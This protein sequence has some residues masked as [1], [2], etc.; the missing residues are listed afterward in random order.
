MV[1]V[2]NSRGRSRLVELVEQGSVG[3][4][5]FVDAAGLLLDDDVSGITVERAN[6]NMRAD[7]AFGHNGNARIRNTGRHIVKIPPRH[8]STLVPFNELRND[9]AVIQ[10]IVAAH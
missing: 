9:L 10:V 7:S 8:Q 1:L 5:Q 4:L 2:V 6:R 3:A